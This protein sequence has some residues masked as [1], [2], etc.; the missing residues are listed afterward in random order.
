MTAGCGP[1][2]LPLLPCSFPA[3]RVSAGSQAQPVQVSCF[4]L[5]AC[6]RVLSMVSAGSSSFALA[7]G[8]V[9]VDFRS[10]E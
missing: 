2:S 5:C 6:L 7:L 8:A 4:L 1:V 3:K 9:M 10:K